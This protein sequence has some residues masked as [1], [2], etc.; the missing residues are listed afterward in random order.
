[1]GREPGEVTVYVEHNGGFRIVRHR[2]DRADVE[3]LV[4]HPDREGAAGLAYRV[5]ELL[6]EGL[7][8]VDVGGALVLDVADVDTPKYL[9]DLI[10]REH[11]YRGEVAITYIEE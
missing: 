9:P 1:M 11:C 5:R 3:Y 2:A 10:S 8:G 6:L 7:P 4:L